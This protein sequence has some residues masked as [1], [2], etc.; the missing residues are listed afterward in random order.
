MMRVKVRIRF[1]KAGDL[2]FVSHHDLMRVFERMMRRAGVPFR[3]NEGFH[4]KPKMAFASALGLGI[5]GLQEIVEI[6]LSEPMPPEEVQRRM[7]SEAP[8]GLDVLSVEP[9]DAQTTAQVRR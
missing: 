9:M 8:A 7:A 3:S 6:E 5:A 2:R 1:R 4:P